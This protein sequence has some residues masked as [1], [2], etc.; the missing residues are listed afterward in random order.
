MHPH[1]TGQVG[2]H[3]MAIFEF[4]SKGG[5]RQGFGDGRRDADEPF[6]GSASRSG[7]WGRVGGDVAN[8]GNAKN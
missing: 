7:G 2:E 1:F 4:G 3:R 5:G 6:I 8:R